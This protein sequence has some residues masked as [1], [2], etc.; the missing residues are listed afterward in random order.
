[1]AERLHT[2]K[3]AIDCLKLCPD[4]LPLAYILLPVCR[5]GKVRWVTCLACLQR[6]CPC[7]QCW[8]GCIVEEIHTTEQVVQAKAEDIQVIDMCPV[9]EIGNQL[10]K[11]NGQPSR[12]G[13]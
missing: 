3:C 12:C 2:V 13:Q 1:M 10:P 7:C 9:I 8:Q 6:F 11:H 5:M 4:L